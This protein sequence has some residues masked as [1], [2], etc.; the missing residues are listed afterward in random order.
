MSLSH[1]ESFEEIE[2]KSKLLDQFLHRA[3]ETFPEGRLNRQDQ[4]ELAYAVATDPVNQVVIINF[5]KP[6]VWVGLPKNELLA[7][8]ELLTE[9]AKE[10]R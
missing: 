4:G 7:L 3:K 9:K 6:V 5:G 1:H 10:L 8:V 2:A